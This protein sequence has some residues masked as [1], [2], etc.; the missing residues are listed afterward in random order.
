MA[1]VLPMLALFVGVITVLRYD[2]GSVDL[3]FSIGWLSTFDLPV[4]FL[5]GASFII[6]ACICYPVGQLCGKLLQSTE[7]LRAYGLNLAGSIVGVMVLFV[8]SLFWLPPTIVS[9][10]PEESVYSWCRWRAA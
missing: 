7:A 6:C 2:T 10:P 9:R 8:M 1:M 5:L 4:Y 3:M